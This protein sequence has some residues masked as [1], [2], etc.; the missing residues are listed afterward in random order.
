MSATPAPISVADLTESL[1]QVA[2]FAPQF[3][4][5][6]GLSYFGPAGAHTASR[7]SERPALWC[8]TGPWPAEH[9][10]AYAPARHEV[11]AL[12]HPAPGGPS[13]QHPA[14]PPVSLAWSDLWQALWR[15]W[16]CQLPTR[17]IFG[18][19]PMFSRMGTGLPDI[20]RPPTCGIFWR[21]RDGFL[22]M[23]RAGFLPFTLCLGVDTYVRFADGQA[24]WIPVFSHPRRLALRLELHN[25][26]DGRVM[27]CHNGV[28]DGGTR[29]VITVR[30][31]RHLAR[32]RAAFY[33]LDVSDFTDRTYARRQAAIK[34]ATQQIERAN[35][36]AKPRLIRRKGQDVE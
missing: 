14:W 7:P 31:S 30:S 27:L 2:Q 5:C 36:Q 35:A 34:Q 33:G 16:Y 22:R 18:H 12:W 1:T 26:T 20:L 6:G 21:T 24:R 32:Q 23:G 4:F 10:S 25:D 3:W 8:R 29:T 19:W 28:P 11:A 13:V 17:L 15:A 9:S